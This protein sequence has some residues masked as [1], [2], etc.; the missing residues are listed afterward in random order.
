[1]DKRKPTDHWGPWYCLRKIL[2]RGL[3]LRVVRVA[4]INN[5]YDIDPR[6]SAAR[7]MLR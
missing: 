5:D 2:T 4:G 7:S 6:H 1:M 3:K